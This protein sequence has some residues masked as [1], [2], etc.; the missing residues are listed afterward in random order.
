MPKALDLTGQKYNRLK[1]VNFDGV[2]RDSKGRT[3]R[4]WKCKCDCGSEVYLTTHALRS[5]NTKSCGCYNLELLKKRNY[6]HGMS[7]SRIYTTWKNMKSRCYYPKNA[8][9]KNYGGRGIKICDEWK[10]DFQVFYEWS[11]KHGYKEELTI[12][13]I[14]NNGNYQPD[15]CRWVDMAVQSRNTSRTRYIEFN[16]KRLTI[17]EW[18]IEIGGTSTTVLYR[19]EQGWSVEEAIMTP[20]GK[21]DWIPKILPTDDERVVNNKK[22]YIRFIGYFNDP[23][24]TIKNIAQRIGITDSCL[25]DW[26]K[27]SC[28]PNEEHMKAITDYLKVKPEHFL[29]KV[30]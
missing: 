8:E 18:G 15:N 19:I 6:L 2:R 13:R 26:K 5:G 24:D 20:I 25:R 30:N 9:F 10:N 23:K 27:G 29:K 12:D 17:C 4:Y 16:G 22:N 14:D 11:I 3:F 21:K 28:H 7:N 1:V